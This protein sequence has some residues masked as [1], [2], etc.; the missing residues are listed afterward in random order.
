MTSSTIPYKRV[1][2]KMSG[3]VLMG[4]QSF[5]IDPEATEQLAKDVAE[6]HAQGLEVCIVVGGGNIH[7]G[8]IGTAHGI[9]QCTS[10]YM[11]MLGT[12]M[13]ALA[14]SSALSKLKVS[15]RVMS[16]I[17]MESVCESYV[18]DRALRHLSKGR[19]VIF[20]SGTGNPY[21]TTDTAG[22]LRASEMKCDLLLKGTKVPGVFSED[23]TV[24]PEAKH[25]KEIKYGQILSENL[26]VMDAAAVA[27]ARETNIP[28][29]VFR[30]QDEG[31][32][33]RV[34]KGEGVF[35]SVQQD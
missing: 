18:R 20:A 28:M 34:L 8:K 1:L 12:V 33:G 22:A 2:L 21:F 4:S 24:N 17:P 7:R 25:Y 16:A 6:V 32:F 35:T 10:D 3:E 14:L 11:G 26:K 13:N 29:V 23:P 30:I 15:N 27:L 9:D 19:V 5:G 31:A